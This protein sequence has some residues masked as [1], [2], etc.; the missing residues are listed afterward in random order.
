MVRYLKYIV[1]VFSLI[2]LLA[3]SFFFMQNRIDLMVAMDYSN[4]FEYDYQS[5]KCDRESKDYL[6]PC[7]KN[8]FAEYLTHVSLTGTGI[9]M[10]MMFNLMDEDREKTSFYKGQPDLQSLHFT[11]NY[12]EVNNLALN[13]VYRRYHGFDALYGGYIASLERYYDKGINFS[14][15]LINGFEGP[16]GFSKVKDKVELEKLTQRFNAAKDDFYQIKNEAKVFID[17]EFKRLR[18]LEAQL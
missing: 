16:D 8:L 13:N 15:N 7:F 10:K 5:A 12:L 17:S 4:Q 6:F 3:G 9:G 1:I 2:G 11:V 18:A 14:Q